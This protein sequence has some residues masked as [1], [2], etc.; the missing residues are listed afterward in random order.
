MEPILRRLIGE[1][2][3]VVIDPGPR[4]GRVKADPGQIEQ[5]VLNLAVNARDAMPEG[6][7]LAIKTVNTVLSRAYGRQHL[8]VKPGHYVMLAAS[9]TGVGMSS[10]VLSHIFEPFFTT[11]EPGKGTG[12]GLATVYGIVKQSGGHVTVESRVGHGTTFKVFL[13]RVE[14]DAVDDS[15]P[16]AGSPARGD[17]T[18]LLAEDDPDVRSL[19]L[20]I[21]QAQG[22]TV[23]PAANGREAMDVAE[24]HRRLIHILVTDVVMPEMNGADLARRLAGLRPGLRVLFMSGYTDD[25]IAR[26]GVLEPGTALLEKPFAPSALTQK[27]REVLDAPAG[28]TP[29]A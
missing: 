19:A 10:E 28:S 20:E 7:D 18:I 15:A 23:L 6:G 29:P 4:L 8:D 26:E 24:R 1:D 22:Y 9:D 5:V 11:K 12:L 13:P 16:E 14:D 27:V 17:E 2:V 21:L 25:V 3:R